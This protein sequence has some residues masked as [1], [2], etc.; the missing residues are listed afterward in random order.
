MDWLQDVA[1]LAGKEDTALV[2]TSPSGFR[3]YQRDLKSKVRRV[4]S[5]LDGVSNYNIREFTDQLDT[6]ALKNGS[7]P[8]YIH[9]MDAAHLVLTVLESNGIDSWQMIHD[10]FG[11][12]ACDIPELHRAIRIAFYKMYDGIDRLAAFADE[13]HTTLDA[14][15]PDRPQMGTMRVKDVLDSEYF[16]G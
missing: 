3:V 5:A 16:F 13:I 6:Q 11:C 14:D 15:L 12:H 4:K 10:D 1:K 7:A 9:S 2:W 8:N